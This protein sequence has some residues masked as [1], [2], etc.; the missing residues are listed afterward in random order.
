MW[1]GNENKIVIFCN[2][3]ESL[4]ANEENVHNQIIKTTATYNTYNLNLT[5]NIE[6]LGLEKCDYYIPFLY[7]ASITINVTDQKTFN[8]EFKIDSYNN[9][10]LLIM[11]DEYSVL[12]FEKCVKN[13]NI[14]KCQI[15][16]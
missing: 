14:L 1:I 6:Y 7:S 12:P 3:K 16:K 11:V 10:P 4:K 2:F 13:S 5:I 9:E 8:F 15:S